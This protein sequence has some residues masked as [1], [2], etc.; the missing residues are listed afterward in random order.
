M[1]DLVKDP[2]SIQ[3]IQEFY[4]AGKP[5]AAVC[6][7]PIVFVNVKVEKDGSSTPL[8]SGREATGFSNEEEEASKLKDAMPILLEDEMKRAGAKYV[9]ADK[10]FGEKVCVD[11]QVITG[12]NPASS[13]G[14][15]QAILK[16]INA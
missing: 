8:L 3:L 14:V 6:H 11:G 2:Q 16:A 15:A 7:G 5:V 9:K 12:Q 4:S 1:F 10:P 13:K